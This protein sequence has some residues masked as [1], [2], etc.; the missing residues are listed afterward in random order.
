M[1]SI[2]VV[3]AKPGLD[4]HD[5]GA[6][7]VARALRDAGVEVIYTGLHQTPEQIVAAAL[8]EDADAIGLS[9]LSG[10]HMTQFR[11]VLEL[12][13][14]RD[15]TDIVVFG[16]G[17]IPDADIAELEQMGVAK[18]FTPGA[19]TTEIVDWV[20]AH[21][22]PAGVVRPEGRRSASDPGGPGAP[23]RTRLRAQAYRTPAAAPHT[24]DGPEWT[25]LSIRRRSSSLTTAF[26]IQRARSP[27]PRQRPAPIA[28]GV[29]RGRQAARRHQGPGQ[30]RRPRQGGRR[31]ARRR[32]RRG[33]GKGRARSSA[34]T[35]RATPCT[36]S[37]S[38]RPA[39]SR[40]ST[41]CRSWSTAPTAPS[42]RSAR[43]R[44]AWRSRR[45]RTTNPEA[46]ARVPVMTR[47]PA[48]TRPRPPRSSPR[49]GSP[50]E[51][52]AGAAALAERLWAVFTGKDA[53]LVEVNPLI[54]T[55]DGQVSALDGKVTLDDNAAFRQ[56]LAAVRRPR[57]GR[58]ARGAGQGEAPELRQA[59]RPGRHHRQ[60]GRPG[61]VHP[62][63]G[64]LRGRG[65]RRDPAGELPRHRRR[66]LGR[67]DGERPGDRAVRPVGPQ[68]PGQRVRRDH[69]VR[70]GGERDRVRDRDAR[71]ARRAGEPPDRGPPRRQ[72]RRRGA[73]DTR[74]GRDSGGRAGR[75]H[76]RRGAA[77][78]RAGRSA[79]T[80]A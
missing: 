47:W 12:L 46:V 30:D 49:A 36:R 8:Q 1:S 28:A 71:R 29:R 80:G 67:G 78:R 16:G 37:W 43:C 53:T 55:A 42:C 35:S 59:R 11:R 38:R 40:R 26:P 58:P 64:R 76:G 41:T 10:A 15:A 63:R 4:G 2:R 54:L 62:R 31:E 66:R 50:A 33:R 52:I 23:G 75:D 24:E 60:R 18:I 34:W 39:T 45:S 70:R 65:I 25:C 72:Q 51:A 19:A 17:I 61:H 79:A 44:A 73:A 68:R 13:A 27:P 22:R 77:R 32:P 5:R 6:K 48:W 14:E 69:L 57:G 74:R 21:A 3:I 9:V 56:D 20:R 7:V